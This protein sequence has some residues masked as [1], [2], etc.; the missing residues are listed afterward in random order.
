MDISLHLTDVVLGSAKT[1]FA[2]GVLGQPSAGKRTL[3]RNL[4]KQLR[5]HD[6]KAATVFVDDCDYI[7]MMR[8]IRMQ[9]GNL[10]RDIREFQEGTAIYL[11]GSD[12]IERG[13]TVLL[14]LATLKYPPDDLAAW[15]ALD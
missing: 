4:T 14:V 7:E 6:R 8:G 12:R 11:A 2:L 9:R 5:L 10:A 3:A 13:T 1:H 15:E